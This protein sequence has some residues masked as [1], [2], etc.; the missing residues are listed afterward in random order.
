MAPEQFLGKANTTM[1]YYALGILS[2]E[3][4]TGISPKDFLVEN[5]INWDIL[6]ISSKMRYILESLLEYDY[7]DR[8]KNREELLKVIKDNSKVKTKNRSKNKVKSKT[9]KKHKKA[10]KNLIFR[11]NKRKRGKKKKKNKRKR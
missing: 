6:D 2:L 7:R 9:V 11:K 10:D 3:M 1:D 4:L 8:I 5:R